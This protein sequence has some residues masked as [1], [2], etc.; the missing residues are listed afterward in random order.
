[1]RG[2]TPVQHPEPMVPTLDGVV[3][4]EFLL[5]RELEECG[6]EIMPVFGISV[7][8]R[9]YENEWEWLEGTNET[10]LSVNVSRPHDWT[11]GI[12]HEPVRVSVRQ[13]AAPVDAVMVT[14]WGAQLADSIG[15]E[16]CTGRPMA[17][18]GDERHRLQIDQRFLPSA[19]LGYQSP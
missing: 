14:K 1:M 12:Y 2:L 18:P 15:A 10:G 17:I 16:V 5:S 6:G 4:F 3:F 7:Y 19:R 8:H 11:Q 9:D 13:K